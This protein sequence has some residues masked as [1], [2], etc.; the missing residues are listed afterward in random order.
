LKKNLHL[1]LDATEA[2]LTPPRG[3]GRYTDQLLRALVRRDDIDLELHLR[4]PTEL[5]EARRATY[6]GAPVHFFR[7]RRRGRLEAG[8]WHGPANRLLYH[9]ST[10][11]VVT[12]HDVAPQRGFG[13]DRRKVTARELERCAAVITPSEHSR[14]GVL[15]V[16]GLDP[17]RV[18]VIA[19]APAADFQ[20]PPPGELATVLERR[21]LRRGGYL[22]HIGSREPRKNPEVLFAAAAALLES[23]DLRL[24]LTGKPSDGEAVWVERLGERLRFLGFVEDDELPALYAGAAALVFPSFDEGYGL[25]VAEALA[26]G[27]PV[28]CSRTGAL[29]EVGGEAALYADPNRVE[30]FIAQLR[31]LIADPDLAGELRERGLRRSD[32]G[33]DDVAAEHA[34]LYHRVA[35]SSGIR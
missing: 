19:E 6:G 11:A 1:A 9:G 23:H 35:E 20:P 30:S 13:R 25:P 10:P 24:V 8:L 27:C 28:V 3:M 29:P 34:A 12:L 16:F 26:C 31:R 5:S 15:E 22:L 2:C 21:G 17:A 33:W 7:R 4:R 32:R 18:V 14:R